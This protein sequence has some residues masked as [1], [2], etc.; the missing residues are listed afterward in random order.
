MSSLLASADPEVFKAVQGEVDRQRYTLEMIASE[1]FCSPAVLAAM[2]TPLTNKYAEGYPG[3]RYYG[4]CASVDIAESL[5][6]ERAK[7]LFGADHAN[8]QPHSGSQANMAAY[9]ALAKPGA[10]VM[11]LKLPHGGHLTHGSSV[12]FSGQLF[13]VVSYG[14]H[15]ETERIE[16]D[17]FIAS[18]N[19]HRPDIVVLGSSAYPRITDFAKFAEAA[20]DAGAKVVADIAHTAGLVAAGVHPTP[21][22]NCDVV[23]T[24]TH[25][26]LRGP[27]G[28]MIL[29]N[30]E[31]RKEIN[32]KVF[33]FSQGGPL[34]HVI[35]AKAVAF[36][37]AL[38]PQF[39][40]YQ[41]QIVENAKAL[42]KRLTD[43]GL[44]L[45]TGGTD[46]H[47]MLLNL[48]PQGLT[49]KETEDALERAGITTNKN[50]VPNETQKPTVTS[51]VRIGTPAL[52]TRGMGIKEMEQVGDWIA[53][54]IDS[55]FDEEVIKRTREQIRELCEAFPLYE[56]WSVA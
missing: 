29:C 31:W 6:I 8:V 43:R 32:K 38:E 39:K 30:E 25:K 41:Q 11:G 42:A 1:N 56:G 15:P 2:G 20:K 12:N 3:R 55:K 34:M 28:G 18:V 9:L 54:V 50:T 49:G 16:L 5:A 22:G 33:P 36:K 24:T 4:G 46:T 23:T 48:T 40:T 53:D 45:V 19:E 14:L 44:T 52:T 27:R 13:N 17:D 47:L 35:A 26:T 51:G 21:V 37:E 7:E 10:T